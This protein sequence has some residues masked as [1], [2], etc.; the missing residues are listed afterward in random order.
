[1]RETHL[2]LSQEHSH[3]AHIASIRVCDTIIEKNFCKKC[4][5]KYT[6]AVN[7]LSD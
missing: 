2:L 7:L 4:F 3:Q 5:F 1:M 6:E